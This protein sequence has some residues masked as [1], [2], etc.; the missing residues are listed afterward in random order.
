MFVDRVRRRSSRWATRAWPAW[1]MREAG[2][3]LVPGG[4]DC[5]AGVAEARALAA[6]VG[7]PV[8]LKAAPAA[9]GM[10]LVA[11]S[12]E[13]DEAFG[14]ASAE[15]AASFGDGGM[16]LEKAVVEP[17][18]VE[19]Q[20]LA[21]ATG[22]VMVLGERDCSIQ[23]RHQKLIE[24]APS[25]AL[26]ADT[27]TA[28]AD[29]AHRACTARPRQRRH[30][31]APAGHRRRVLFHRDEHPAAGRAP[32]PGAGHRHGHRL[33]AA[34]HRGRRGASAEGLAELSGHAIASA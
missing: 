19:M 9:A 34:A 33:L 11:G 25:P 32:G 6:E 30:R 14:L 10:R 2:V 12:Q 24:E 20:V 27:R 29:A 5:L 15:A 7:Y 8:L 22:R 18:H 17:R 16:Y 23:R 4:A 13:L 3:P 28:M 26:D 31:G 1:T 21:D